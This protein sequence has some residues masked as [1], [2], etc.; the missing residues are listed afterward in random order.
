MPC[1]GYVQPMSYGMG[2]VSSKERRRKGISTM[3][4]VYPWERMSAHASALLGKAT[5]TPVEFAKLSV[6]RTRL[7]GR[8]IAVELGLDERRLNF[9]RWLVEH[10]RLTE[11]VRSA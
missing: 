5:F 2:A 11:D 8:A 9:A 4:G 10:D 1:R 3:S 6:L 7:Q